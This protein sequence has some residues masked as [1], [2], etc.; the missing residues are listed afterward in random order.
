[1]QPWLIIDANIVLSAVRFQSVAQV[2]DRD[3][4][5]ALIEMH[6]ANR[7]VWV[8]SE[9]ILEEYEYQYRKLKRQVQHSKDKRRFDDKAFNG[10][11]AAIRQGPG[12]VEPTDDLVRRACDALMGK[13]RAEHLQDPD[14]AIYL[15]AAEQA[16]TN[17]AAVEMLVGSNDSDLYSLGKYLDIPI[18]T[19]AELLPR[20][21]QTPP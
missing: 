20:L 12:L 1:M 2:A 7:F 13:G 21:R 14:D 16:R 9:E 11:I 3:P 19:S 5:Y 4:A 6:K 8:Y 10:L 17:Q 18:L 15:A